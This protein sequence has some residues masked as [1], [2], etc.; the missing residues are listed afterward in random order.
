LWTF[1]PLVPVQGGASVYDVRSPLPYFWI[2]PVIAA[3][4]HRVPPF[5]KI[6][7]RKAWAAVGRTPMARIR[8]IEALS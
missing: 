7:T 8:R 2:G 3:V 6:W 4:V 5:T 1:F